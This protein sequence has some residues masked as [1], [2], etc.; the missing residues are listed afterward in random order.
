VRA[1]QRRRHHIDPRVGALRR[2]H[3]GDEQLEIVLVVERRARVRIG[4]SQDREDGVPP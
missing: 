1:E 2:E 3:H 4:L